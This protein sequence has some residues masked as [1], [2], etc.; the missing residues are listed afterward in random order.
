MIEVMYLRDVEK[1][2]NAEVASYLQK[3]FQEIDHVLHPQTEGY[4]LYVENFS[5]LYEKRILNTILLYHLLMK[6][7]LRG[8][9]KLIYKVILLKSHYFLTMSS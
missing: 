3:R 9:R 8:L 2:D 7:Y 1:I 5:S 6:V 4:F